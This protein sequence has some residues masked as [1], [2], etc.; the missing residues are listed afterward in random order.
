MRC[1]LLRRRPATAR[2]L[3]AEV[4]AWLQ[5]Q[6]QQH[7]RQETAAREQ[8]EDLVEQM[9]QAAAAGALGQQQ[10]PFGMQHSPAACWPPQPPA[11][12]M[13]AGEAL[14]Q[15]PQTA[16]RPLHEP[17]QPVLAPAPGSGSKRRQ[18][19]SRPP[20]RWDYRPAWNEGLRVD[21][22]PLASRARQA[23]ATGEPGS[24]KQHSRADASGRTPAAWAAA[25][26]PVL[27]QPTFAA[28]PQVQPVP[29][30]FTACSSLAQPVVQQ[31]AQQAQQEQQQL[32]AYQGAPPQPAPVLSPSAAAPGSAMGQ[33]VIHQYF[34]GSPPPVTAVASPPG[35]WQQ[36]WHHGWPPA[37]P[38]P[39]SRP[40]TAG[41]QHGWQVVPPSQLVCF[42]EGQPHWAGYGP[43][44]QQQG[45]QQ[46]GQ[47]PQAWQQPGATLQQ[48]QLQVRPATP[49]AGLGVGG[50]HYD[51]SR[52]VGSET[53][54][55][56]AANAV[57]TLRPRSAAAKVGRRGWAPQLPTQPDGAPQQIHGGGAH[58]QT[59]RPSLLPSCRPLQEAALAAA[60]AEYV[61]ETA[62]IRA[63]RL[64]EMQGSADLQL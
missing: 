46:P 17:R 35:P 9:L 10:G 49:G 47:Y 51:S 42:G 7:Q 48:A 4:R 8:E 44:V 3:L 59:S 38:D 62:R 19:S 20:S 22:L 11:A 33:P 56:Q 39:P 12:A 45:V 21:D 64:R 29:Q 58:C 18:L 26:A 36:Q 14:G 31:Q 40:V 41:L 2:P 32:L 53:W 6:Q 25:P 37:A 55:P 5:Q 27:Q 1:C 63:K 60:R 28:Q 15:Q 24:P 50:L 57:N 16:R 54:Q 43:P 61:R 13:Q 23:G 52:D 30:M 34:A